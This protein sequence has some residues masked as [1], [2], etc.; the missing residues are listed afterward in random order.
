MHL[1]TRRWTLSPI[2]CEECSADLDLGD[3]YDFLLVD[4]LRDVLDSLL[5]DGLGDVRDLLMN[6]SLGHLDH[7][8]DILHLGD[9]DDAFLHLVFQ[10][11][12]H[13]LLHKSQPQQTDKQ[14]IQHPL[15]QQRHSTVCEQIGASSL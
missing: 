6:N 10:D 2:V 13:A 4:D 7:A 14:T 15:L 1:Q 8:I 12:H 3:F 9:F 5:N 11:L